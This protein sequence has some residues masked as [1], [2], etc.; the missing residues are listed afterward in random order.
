V[1]R[2]PVTT[3][4]TR[5]GGKASEQSGEQQQRLLLALSPDSTPDY[6]DTD[7][8][9]DRVPLLSTASYAHERKGDS[10]DLLWE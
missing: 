4:P 1:C 7:G 2:V 8:E 3:S 10:S 9:M 6:F 5:N